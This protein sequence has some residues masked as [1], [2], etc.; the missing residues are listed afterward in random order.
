MCI[1]VVLLE[2]LR[3]G[4]NKFVKTGL[5]PDKLPETTTT[6]TI[7]TEKP[8]GVYVFTDGAFSSKTKRCGL[9]VAFDAPFESCA[10]SKQ[11]RIGSTHQQAELEAIVSAL[12]IISKH[13]ELSHKP[14]VTIWT[15]SEYALKCFTVH[16]HGWRKNGWVTAHGEPVKYMKLIEE[17]ANIL[18]SQSQNVKLRHISEVGIT[19]HATYESI[20]NAPLITRRVW[21]GNK[22]ADLLA[23][24]L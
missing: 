9:G 11:L 23:K 21:E 20:K 1:L 14:S 12:W 18:L 16:I 5:L 2:C 6:T 13:Y 22:N 7:V 3:H 4:R 17:G 10:I 24:G 15:D 19:S 8:S